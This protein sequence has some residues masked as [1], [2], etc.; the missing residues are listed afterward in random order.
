MPA[1][2]DQMLQALI[3]QQ[4]GAA[5]EGA[6]GAAPGGAPAGV[7]PEA[8]AALAAAAA[9]GGAPAGAEAPPQAPPQASKSPTQQEQG[10]AKIAPKDSG[11]EPSFEFVS[12]DDGEGGKRDLTHSQIA[13][14]MTRYRD[15]NHK[16][17]TEVAPMKPVLDVVKQ[18]VASAKEKG[19]D[20][21]GEEV[22]ELI[23]A[24]VRAYTSNPQMGGDSKGG[25]KEA[26]QPAEGKAQAPMGEPDDDGLTAWEKENAVKLPPGYKEQLGAVKG[27]GAKMDQIMQMLQQ[28]AGAGGAAGQAMTAAGEQTKLAQTAQMSAAKQAVT[29]NIQQAMTANKMTPADLKD[30]Q[31][32]AMARGYSPEDFIDPE[33]T[34]TVVT[35]FAANRQAPEIG[36]L[37]DIAQ[38][39]QAFTGAVDGAPG[40]AMAPAAPPADPMLA[41]LVS[42]A[43]ASRN[44]G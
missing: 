38:R 3:A 22:A 19:Y 12:I 26:A 11:E 43:M 10:A 4:L 25:S 20:A 21:K 27:L 6:P 34:Q 31:A 17:Q 30:F 24:A 13:G 39:R 41:Q 33:L 9:Q 18:I 42:G 15:L 2:Q 28:A 7:P 1:P 5:P 37:R 44:M 16:W 36:R 35:D 29:T 14:T 40:G 23:T 8:A 32:F